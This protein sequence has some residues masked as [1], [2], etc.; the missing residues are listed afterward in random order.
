M[1]Q[2]LYPQ[3]YRC[4][5]KLGHL[6]PNVH[7]SNV[8]N[9]QTE[10]E[11]T[12]PFNRWMGKEDVVYIYNGILLSH[13]K[14]Q[15]PTISFDVDGTWGYYAQWNKNLAW[16]NWKCL[17]NV[18]ATSAPSSCISQNDSSYSC[19]HSNCW[20][21]WVYVGASGDYHIALKR[22]WNE[23]GRDLGIS[24]WLWLWVICILI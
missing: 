6:H 11:P 18:A 23:S 8:H 3:R 2:Q 14:G 22:V 13:Q 24:W 21:Y 4:N 19:V 16:K 20:D 17:K 9:N 12:T 5:E 7:S 1:T 10:E 15:I